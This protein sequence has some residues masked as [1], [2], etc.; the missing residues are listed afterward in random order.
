[1]RDERSCRR[2]VYRPGRAVLLADGQHWTFPAPTEG[3]PAGAGQ[4]GPDYEALLRAIIEAEDQDERRRVELALAIT[5]LAC[6]YQLA[7]HDYAALLDFG[8]GDPAL[9]AV[10]AALGEI[11]SDHLRSFRPTTVEVPR[12]RGWGFLSRPLR[13]LGFPSVRRPC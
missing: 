5:L 2:T 3:E 7:A 12:R 11:A 6:N 10:Q 4:V 1:M 8:P 13:L 9:S